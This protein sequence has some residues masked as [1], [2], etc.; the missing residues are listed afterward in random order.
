MAAYKGMFN[1]IL[2]RSTVIT[3]YCFI[4]LRILLLR[5]VAVGGQKAIIEVGIWGPFTQGS[6]FRLYSIYD[7]SNIMYNFLLIRH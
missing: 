7:G 6:K 4:L 3:F 1:I 5:F 2:D